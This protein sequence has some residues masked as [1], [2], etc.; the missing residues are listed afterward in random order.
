MRS[1]SLTAICNEVPMIEEAIKKA[2]NANA[3]GTEFAGQ[4][5]TNREFH[6]RMER[7]GVMTKK[8]SFTIPL[9]ERIAH[10]TK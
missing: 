4:L 8:Q 5:E 2:L 1:Q 3:R 6:S 9:M 10:L 7:A